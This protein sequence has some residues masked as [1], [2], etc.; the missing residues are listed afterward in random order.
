MR[1]HRRWRT[2][3]QAQHAV[4]HV[5]HCH[6]RTGVAL[7]TQCAAGYQLHTATGRAHQRQR[8]GL[9]H[10]RGYCQ[11]HTQNKPR[12]HRADKAWCLADGLQ[13]DH[14][15]GLSRIDSVWLTSRTV[16][17]PGLM[18]MRKNS[19]Q[20]TTE[21][22]ILQVCFRPWIQPVVAKEIDTALLGSP[23]ALKARLEKQPL[24]QILF[25]GGFEMPG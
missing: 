13:Y 3:R 15:A 18:P 22:S 9:Q 2:Q 5:M 25:S 1:R 19:A 17:I 10:R 4:Q 7:L 23:A 8:L 6:R 12:Q 24:L 11:A 21:C 16:T 14:G 20:R